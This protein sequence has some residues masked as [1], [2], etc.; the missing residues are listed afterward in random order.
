M[1]NKGHFV[2]LKHK[3][4]MVQPCDGEFLAG[5]QGRLFL[6]SEIGIELLGATL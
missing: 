2:A 1:L 4:M 6:G 3:K 5:W